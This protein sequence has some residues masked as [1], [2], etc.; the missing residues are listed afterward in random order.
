M[1]LSR[2]E[3]SPIDFHGLRIFD[4]TAGQSLGSSVA[5][6]EVAPGASH[7]EAWSRRS[8]KYYLVSSGEVRFALDGEPHVLKGGDF[9]F[10]KQGRRFSYANETSELAT[11][12]LVHT[13]SFDLS[14]EVFVDK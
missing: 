7:A 1:L 10:V 3:M 6:I 8:D 4:Y 11:L 12:V 2:S 5:V 9:C 14:Q 13:P